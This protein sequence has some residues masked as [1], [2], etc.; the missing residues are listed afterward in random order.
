MYYLV[1]AYSEIEILVWL[2]D[3]GAATCT[4]ARLPATLNPTPKP[5]YVSC[6][7]FSIPIPDARAR[8][9][10]AGGGRQIANLLYA[11]GEVSL[12]SVG[13]DALR[14]MLSAG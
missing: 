14:C 13:T 2:V 10:D 1:Q 7:V 5:T 8:V 6:C 9:K 12:G 11:I 4:A 3:R